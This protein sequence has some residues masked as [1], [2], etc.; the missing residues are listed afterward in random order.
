MTGN[1]FSETYIPLWATTSQKAQI[2]R[3]SPFLYLTPVQLGVLAQR[4]VRKFCS[5]CHGAGCEHCGQTG[6]TGRT[7]VFELLVTT[8]AIRAQIHAQ[9]SEADIRAAAMADG[10]ALMREDGER[11]IAAGIT[12]RE[13]VL[14]V[15]RD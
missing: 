10:M 1:R 5:H 12:S 2:S 11:L 8:D 13:E 7:G 6:Y 3:L 15:T 14:R 9:A 4:L